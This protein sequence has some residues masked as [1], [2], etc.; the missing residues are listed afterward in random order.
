MIV[1]D[2]TKPTAL[3]DKAK[4]AFKLEDAER[5]GKEAARAKNA[6]PSDVKR[7]KSSHSLHKH[8]NDDVSSTSLSLS[9]VAKSARKRLRKQSQARQD[10]DKTDRD[11]C[12]DKKKAK[13]FVEPLSRASNIANV[14][15]L[16]VGEPLFFDARF[17]DCS[18]C[19]SVSNA[20]SISMALRQPARMCRRNRSRQRV[21]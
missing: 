12:R 15:R 19:R 4:T 7:S 17:A 14:P 20:E 3:S 6:K 8:Q 11:A 10:A 1:K 2:R 16:T 13:G 9:T 18:E 5:R 21:S